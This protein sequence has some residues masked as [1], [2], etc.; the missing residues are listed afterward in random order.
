[1][2]SGDL[3]DDVIAVV[4]EGLANV[5]RHAEASHA[6]VHVSVADGEV[7]VVVEDDGVGPGDSPRLSG[8]RNLRDRATHR[9]GTFTISPGS[10]A[11]TRLQWA[12][13]T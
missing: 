4:N 13:P 6:E 12:V 7:V 5:V 2:V 10:P 8:L 3:I 1:M 9:G 11:G